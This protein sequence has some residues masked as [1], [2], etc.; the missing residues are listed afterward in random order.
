MFLLIPTSHQLLL[1]RNGYFQTENELEKISTFG[2][3]NL[4]VKIN[5]KLMSKNALF[6]I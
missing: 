3:H 6:D 4:I 5:T 2:A 1:L